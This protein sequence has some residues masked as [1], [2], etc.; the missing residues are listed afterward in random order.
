MSKYQQ[1]YGR[2]RSVSPQRGVSVASARC[3]S[4]HKGRPE[5][6]P[7]PPAR[8]R[9][10]APSA[11]AQKDKTLEGQRREQAG[12][13]VGRGNAPEHQKPS[14]CDLDAR[15][16]LL[17]AQQMLQDAHTS[18]THPAATEYK[19]R[20]VSVK[21]QTSPASE[22]APPRPVALETEYRH[23][24]QGVVPP[25]GPR[26]R[27]HLEPHPRLPLFHTRTRSQKAREELENMLHPRHDDPAHHRAAASLSQRRRRKLT[28]YQ[29]NF[30]TPRR[31]GADETP[32]VALLREKASW[33]RRRDWG[34]NFCPNYLSQ[35]R[36]PFNVL[37][38]PGSDGGSRSDPRDP[39]RVEALDLAGCSAFSS[40]PESPPRAGREMAASREQEENPP[41]DA[42]PAGRSG[43]EEA[44]QARRLETEEDTKVKLIPRIDEDWLSDP[45]QRCCLRATILDSYLKIFNPLKDW[46][47]SARMLQL[48]V[49]LARLSQDLKKAQ[50]NVTDDQRERH[51]QRFHE[52]LNQ[53]T[54]EHRFIKALSE[55]DLLFMDL[56]DHCVPESADR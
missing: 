28:E 41:G 52:T 35:L 43:P 37:W 48:Y 22:P 14:K 3:R 16:P 15:S 44:S 47:H 11:A 39:P 23:S 7:G 9:S 10:A 34:T 6:R 13:Q 4:H 19:P 29:A 24:F 46:H 53:M 8:A 42:D 18:P 56:Q 27:K 54:Q 17:K 45:M 51:V 55:V 31:V 26:L 33:Y 32:Q 1:C 5:K 36:S 20:T 50:C 21:T 25:R 49:D 30:S 38:E 40:G 2:S 12:R